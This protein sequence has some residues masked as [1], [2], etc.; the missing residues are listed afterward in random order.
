[1]ARSETS[2]ESTVILYFLIG[3][4]GS[5]CAESLGVCG[6]VNYYGKMCFVSAVIGFTTSISFFVMYWLGAVIF[7]PSDASGD[8]GKEWLPT[9]LFSDL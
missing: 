5:A 9:I 7:A 3:F 2:I 1:M 4:V 6:S 8:W